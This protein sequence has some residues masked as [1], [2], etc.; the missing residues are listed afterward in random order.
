MSPSSPPSGNGMGPTS[1]RRT[2][3]AIEAAQRAA[4]HILSDAP[5]QL[6]SFRNRTTAT[7]G[8]GL[9][10]M[11]MDTPSVGPSDGSFMSKMARQRARQLSMIQHQK[12]RANARQIL[13]LVA[14]VLVVLLFL[15]EGE[16]LTQDQRNLNHTRT[17]AGGN[18]A[19]DKRIQ[20][21][22]TASKNK[23]V[24]SSA[25][26]KKHEKHSK[27]KAQV[28]EEMAEK[29]RYKHQANAKLKQPEQS[30]VGEGLPIHTHAI[31]PILTFT[32]HTNLITTPIENLSDEEDRALSQNVRDIIAMHPGSA[33]NFLNDEDCLNSIRN[34]LGQNT[35]LAGYF[36]EETK[37]MYKADIC[38]GAALYETGGLYF[39][40]DIEPRVSLWDAVAPTTEF[41]TILVHKDSNHLGGFFQAFIGVTPRSPLMMRYLLLFVDY[42]EGR[43]QVDGPLGVYFLR[44][45]YNQVT[46][47][48]NTYLKGKDRLPRPVDKMDLWQEV[49]YDPARFPSI[50]REKW[51]QRR[52]CQMMVVAPKLVVGQF[53]RDEM[54]P[55]FSRSNGS[56]MC[57]GHDTYKKG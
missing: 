38:R 39:D 9:H 7:N 40:I 27:A 6:Q 3:A 42:Y 4:R 26:Q 52:A 28:A 53:R 21:D 23:F 17:N 22:I 31:P 48:P 15:L 34:A 56:R 5:I 20:N 45:A 25:V 57:G 41:V 11:V 44:F 46:D 12:D 16:H 35:T 10:G 24:T 32:Y 19:K 18:A 30:A 51:G 49:R 13:A 1:R 47:Q 2:S 8:S 14:V 43:L 29:E 37:G 54:V 55:F 33:V 36:S 50:K